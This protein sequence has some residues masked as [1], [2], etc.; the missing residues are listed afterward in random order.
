[1]PTSLRPDGV[2]I[3]TFDLQL[4]VSPFTL[5]R[6]L[7]EDRAPALIDIRSEPGERTLRGAEIVNRSDWRPDGEEIEIVLFDNDGSEASAFAKELQQQGYGGVK[8]LYGGL[9]LY[10]FALD[11]QVVGDETFLVRGDG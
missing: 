9:D 7:R 1:M 3:V 10:E 11:P 6:R 5:F 2:P 4:E 8:A